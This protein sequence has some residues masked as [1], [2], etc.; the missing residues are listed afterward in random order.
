MAIVLAGCAPGA[1]S[2]KPADPSRIEFRAEPGHRGEAHNDA[3]AV[4]GW[5]ALGTFVT[6]FTVFVL[7]V[8]PQTR[9]GG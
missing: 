6:G 9:A 5:V 1:A 8:L 7:F 2:P 3:W 4:A